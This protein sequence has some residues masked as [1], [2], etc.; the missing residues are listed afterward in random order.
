LIAEFA[1]PGEF[2]EVMRGLVP[3][4]DLTP[5]DRTLVAF[6]V[7]ET[8]LIW[9]S[10]GRH[11]LFDL[12]SDPAETADLAPRNTPRTSGLARRAEDW[13]QRP[14]ARSPVALPAR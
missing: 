4:L 10:D 12:E 6:R 8:K 3:G 14:A 13:L 5:W 9:G 2:L 1:R 7:G 11:L